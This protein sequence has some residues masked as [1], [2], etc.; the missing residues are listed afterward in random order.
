MRKILCLL[1][2]TVFVLASCS[3]NP[4]PASSQDESS[5][6][7]T[8]VITDADSKGTFVTPALVS[9][10]SDASKS[11]ADFSYELF[12]NNFSKSENVL[13]SPVSV[14]SPLIMVL[15]GAN[16]E[17][18]KAFENVLGADK[19]TLNNF[20]SS[21]LKSVKNDKNLS[22]Y[23]S[24]WVNENHNIKKDFTDF[25]SKHFKSEVYSV[26]MTLQTVDKINK[27][28][29]QK[30]DG[31]IERI[32]DSLDGQTVMALINATL[33]EAKWLKGYSDDN[34]TEMTFT[35]YNSNKKVTDFMVSFERSYIEGDGF[36]G[37]SKPYANERFSFM[38]LIPDYDSNIETLVS[39]LSGNELISLYKNAANE[40]VR[41]YLPEFKVDY[42]TE[43]NS[44]LTNMG[45]GIAFQ[46]G[47][48]DFSSICNKCYL[49]KVIHSTSIEVKKEGTKAAAATAAIVNKL[50]INS[51]DNQIKTVTLDRPFIYAIIDN[52]ADIP[53]FI[54]TIAEI[55]D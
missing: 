36:C 50:S 10:K 25:V 55:N 26:P 16:G 43:L 40:K 9:I 39:T 24:V 42:K 51:D 17:T 22:L 49:D 53:I 52:Q 19:Q 47:R 28:V 34:I 8:S 23:Q 1:L 37:F 2:T 14:I 54:G 12:K 20:L 29:S 6:K 3:K 18:L 38:A 21:Y 31:E 35:D 11:A 15:N 27:W 46:N 5:Q 7:S 32:V 48:A 44:V 33:F 13:I 41:A 4:A 45:L 30:T